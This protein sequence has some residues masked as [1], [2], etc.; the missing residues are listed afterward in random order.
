MAELRGVISVL[1][2]PFHND[3]SVDHASLRRVIDLYIGAGVNGLTALGVTSEVARLTDV[4]RFDV[5]GTVMEAADGRVPVVVGTTADGLRACIDYTRAAAEAGA[6]A[7][8]VNPPRLVKLN[9]AAILH[10]FSGLAEAVDIPIVIQDY[11]PI[12]GYTLEASLLARIAREV[13]SAR[14]I[15]LEDPPTPQKIAALRKEEGMAAVSIL[16]GLGGS[17]LLEE[18]LAGADGAMTGFA[19]P[20]MLIEVVNLYTRGA[21]R[22]AA[23]A[24]YRYSP[25]MRFEFQPGIGMGI[26]KELLRRRGVIEHPHVRAPGGGI[27]TAARLAIG[28]LLAWLRQTSGAAW[29]PASEGVSG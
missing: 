7:V 4:E 2:T 27:D 15:K 10:H 22:E 17:Y 8:M 26:R 6:A 24:F 18:L 14:T 23:A 1:P 13:P 21:E 11:P 12:A 3:G 20:E 9:S 25:L 16:G 29:L 5:L 19:F 28:S